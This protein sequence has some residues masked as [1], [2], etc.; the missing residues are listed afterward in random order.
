MSPL[1][2]R[3]GGIPE[4]R[5]RER[6]GAAAR[7]SCILTTQLRGDEELGAGGLR[8]RIIFNVVGDERSQPGLTPIERIGVFPGNLLQLKLVPVLE[9]IQ[10]L[11]L[12]G[13]VGVIVRPI[14]GASSSRS[15]VNGKLIV[16]RVALQPPPPCGNRMSEAKRAKGGAHAHWREMLARAAVSNGT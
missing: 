3:T 1:I 9:S 14:A 15:L 5:S 8:R 6:R 2:L 11:S 13:H 10:E 7:R 16:V 12:P 4:A